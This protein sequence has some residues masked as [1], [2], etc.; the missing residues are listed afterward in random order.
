MPRHASGTRPRHRRTQVDPAR[1]AA[2]DVVHAVSVRDAYANLVLASTLRERGLSGQDAAFTTE[3]V[4]GTLRWRGTYDDVLARC[5][6]RPLPDLDP[7]VFDVLRIGTHQLLGMRVPAH[8]AVA[9]SVDLGRDVAGVG[10]SKFV[11]AVLRKVATRDL[12]GW[13]DLVAPAYDADPVGHL[14]TVHAHPRWI[15]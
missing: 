15:V 5:V 3:L 14:A 11:N 9:T 13:L 8:A 7:D 6:N 12:A 10:A 2:Y 4:G 1:R